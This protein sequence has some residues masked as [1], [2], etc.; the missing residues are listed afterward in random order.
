MT[1]YKW[2]HRKMGKQGAL[3]GRWREINTREGVVGNITMWISEKVIRIT[4]LTTYLKSPVRYITVYKYI[5]IVYMSVSHL[6]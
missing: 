2:F 1:G 4:L 3:Y 5:H 6:V